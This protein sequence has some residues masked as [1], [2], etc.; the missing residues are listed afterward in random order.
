[1]RPRVKVLVFCPGIIELESI[2]FALGLAY[3]AISTACGEEE[4]KSLFT[5]LHPRGVLFVHHDVPYS[6]DELCAWAKQQDPEVR[7]MAVVHGLPYAWRFNV[8]ER[9]L[10]QTQPNIAV[11]RESLKTLVARKR[12]PKKAAEIIPEIIPE[13]AVTA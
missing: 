10:C 12:G 1:M 8:P 3:F 7:T 4:F 13:T 11:L 9:V 6:L 5:E 2:A